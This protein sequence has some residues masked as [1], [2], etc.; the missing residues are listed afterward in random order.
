MIKLKI[1]FYTMKRI[2]F[3]LLILIG[4]PVFGQSHSNCWKDVNYAGDSL[5]Y[6]SLDIY[7][8]TIEKATYPV[9]VYVYGSAWLSNASKGA[10][11]NTIGKALLDAG[12]AVVTP[13]HR[14]SRDAIFPAP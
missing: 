11:M 6:H 12:F 1:I 5:A 9:V 13:N 10:D 3:I 2:G 7:L 8:P 14:S 4:L